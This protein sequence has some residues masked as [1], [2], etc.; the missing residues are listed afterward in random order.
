M[1]VNAL[2]CC[3]VCVILTASVEIIDTFDVILAHLSSLTEG[4]VAVG[5][6][7][8]GG[9]TIL[10]ESSSEIAN[11]INKVSE[12]NYFYKSIRTSLFHQ[13]LKLFRLCSQYF[14]NTP[15]SAHKCV[16]VTV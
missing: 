11:E 13:L 14:K 2:C 8:H 16:N 3:H 15:K 7:D 10:R 4:Y 9:L 5:D 6:G 12:T 1:R